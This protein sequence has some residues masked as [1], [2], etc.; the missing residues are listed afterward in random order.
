[1]P[2]YTTLTCPPDVWTQLTSADVTS[3]TFQLVDPASVVRIKCTADATAPTDEQGAD[4]YHYP[5]GQR[6]IA[7]TELA[8]GMTGARV[9]AMPITRAAKIKV[10]HA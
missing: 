6:A 10:G 8:E 4:L 5:E 1:M 2:R 9:W 7:M 3:I